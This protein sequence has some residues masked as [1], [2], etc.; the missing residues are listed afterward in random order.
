MSKFPAK[1][2]EKAMR[3]WFGGM[4]SSA[5][6]SESVKERRVHRSSEEE[7]SGDGENSEDRKM[8]D[9]TTIRGEFL[10]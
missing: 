6:T 4:F 9:F 7:G 8:S 2:R 1:N 10:T 5:V 3:E